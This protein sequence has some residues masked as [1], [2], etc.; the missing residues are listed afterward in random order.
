MRAVKAA[1]VIASLDFTRI[2][3]RKQ[4][5]DSRGHY[6]RLEL[7]SLRVDRTSPAHVH[8]SIVHGL[9]D[10]EHASGVSERLAS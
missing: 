6:G 8:G 2:D 9:V 7:L 10:L 1:V 4:L 5:I 3:K